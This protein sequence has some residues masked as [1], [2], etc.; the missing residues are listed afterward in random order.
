MCIYSTCTYTQLWFIQINLWEVRFRPLS[1]CFSSR[2]SQMACSSNGAPISSTLFAQPAPFCSSSTAPTYFASF[3]CIFLCIFSACNS[4]ASWFYVKVGMTLYFRIQWGCADQ[5][6]GISYVFPSGLP[7]G[8]S[9]CSG[10][11]FLDCRLAD[12]LLALFVWGTR[13]VSLAGGSVCFPRI[14]KTGLC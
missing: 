12:P 14:Q 6:C 1:C 5:I 13:P 7:A 9:L 8:V 10:C 4:Q 3:L 2:F 11:D